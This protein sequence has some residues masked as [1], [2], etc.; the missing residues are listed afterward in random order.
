MKRP[1]YVR[2]SLLIFIR[3][4]LGISLWHVML[5][6]QIQ[7]QYGPL[8]GIKLLPENIHFLGNRAMALDDLRAIFRSAGTVT[9]QISAAQMDI[10]DTNRMNHAL[11][12][13][14]MFYRNRGFVK[15]MI[16]L[17]EFNFPSVSPVESLSSAGGKSASAGAKMELVIKISEKNLY[18]LGQIKVEGLKALPQDQVIAML[19]LQQEL[20]I[21]SSN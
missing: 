10:Y 9:A 19:N 8:T 16:E 17:P 7:A 21:N 11:E 3:I 6:N 1:L 13:I 14:Q 2:A 20:P 15:V 4:L 12:M 5:T 18:H